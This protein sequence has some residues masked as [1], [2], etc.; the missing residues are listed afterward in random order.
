MQANKMENHKETIAT[1]I[2]CNYRDLEIL[3]LLVDI[4]LLVRSVLVNDLELIVSLNNE[5]HELV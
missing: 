2:E 4:V 1:N 3:V 5:L